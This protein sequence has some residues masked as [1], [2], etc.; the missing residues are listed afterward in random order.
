MCFY[1]KEHIT[2]DTATETSMLHMGTKTALIVFMFDNIFF[3]YF[4]I[5]FAIFLIFKF[6][7]IIKKIK[8]TIEVIPLLS[9]MG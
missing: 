2:P 5:Y 7:N 3:I 1:F 6:I 9:M 8:K 4:A